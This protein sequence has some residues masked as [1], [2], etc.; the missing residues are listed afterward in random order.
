MRN[1]ILAAGMLTMAAVA[2]SGIKAAEETKPSSEM[3]AVPGVSAHLTDGHYKY[4]SAK[5]AATGNQVFAACNDSGIAK[6]R[7][8]NAV[9]LLE[10]AIA[11]KPASAKAIKPEIKFLNARVVEMKAIETKFCPMVEVENKYSSIAYNARIALPVME[12]ARADMAST[13]PNTPANC[14]RQQLLSTHLTKQKA[15]IVAFRKYKNATKTR[16]A[17]VNNFEASATTQLKEAEA[18][19]AKICPQSGAPFVPDPD[20]DPYFELSKQYDAL[21]ARKKQ[22]DNIGISTS[23]CADMKAWAVEARAHAARGADHSLRYSFN[24]TVEALLKNAKTLNEQA[25]AY[26]K[27]CV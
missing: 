22:I 2:A 16:L 6:N 26:E 8:S 17:E 21:Q 7:Y 9:Q 14:L 13:T 5:T 12:W 10:K 11:D 3:M 4:G 25:A 15:E 24:S 20:S 19:A 27:L 1:S 18:N 23:E